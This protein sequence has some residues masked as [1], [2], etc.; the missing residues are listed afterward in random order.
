MSIVLS[1][2]LFAVGL[3]PPPVS[4]GDFN[5]LASRPFCYCVDVPVEDVDQ[6]RVSAEAGDA[7]SARLLS[8]ALRN[9]PETEGDADDWLA[10]S[11]ALG[12]SISQSIYGLGLWDDGNKD[13]AMFW[14]ERAAIQGLR[15]ASNALGTM[16][17][18]LG[19]KNQAAF[20]ARR[21]GLSG[22]VSNLEYNLLG[23]AEM[24]LSDSE[25]KAWRALATRLGSEH[26]SE[27]CDDA[28]DPQSCG[29]MLSALEAE[30]HANAKS[31]LELLKRDSEIY[32]KYWCVP[33]TEQS[34]GRPSK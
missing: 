2:M 22:S 7:L 25:S 13:G 16:H 20:W 32:T 31:L 29:R 5:A 28:E 17:G 27:S 33:R 14:M 12:N 6:L 23:G 30:F 11:A 10:R 24:R 4:E 3:P 21:A 9:N 18:D 8:F 15:E 26:I 19:D 1:L 34:S